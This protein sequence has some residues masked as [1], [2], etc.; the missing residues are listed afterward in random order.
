MEGRVE[1]GG[2]EGGGAGVEGVEE[3]A[4]GARG[5]EEGVEVEGEG[6]GEVFCGLGVSCVLVGFGDA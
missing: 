6:G 2:E 4:E 3:R 1:D 5:G